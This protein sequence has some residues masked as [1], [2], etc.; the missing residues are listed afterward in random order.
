[1]RH[2]LIGLAAGLLL[3]LGIAH[4]DVA[5]DLKAGQPLQTV[6]MNA[7]KDKASIE[8][9]LRQVIEASPDQALAAIT[10]AM[11]LSPDQAANIVSIALARQY[12]LNPPQVVAAALQGAPEKAGIIVPTAIVKSPSYFTVPIVQRALAEGVDGS[13]FLPQAIRTAPRQADSILTQALRSAPQQ[14]ES[15]MRAVIADQPDKATHYVRVA[16]EAKAP[17]AAVL[18]G[19]LKAAPRQAD[20]IAAVAGEKGVPSPVIAGAASSAGVEVAGLKAD[21]PYMT[22]L[23]RPSNISVSPFSTPSAGGGG[24]GG[25]G[26]SASPN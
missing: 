7:L 3:P 10:A 24:G 17:P 21:Q 18:A 23:A 26:G 6:L 12:N 22:T 5:S 1:M 8:T 2:T 11:Q 4:A 9:A 16:L 15:I 14:T 19:A 13:K 20:A 25:S